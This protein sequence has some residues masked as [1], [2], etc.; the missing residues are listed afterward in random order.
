MSANKAYGLFEIKAVN[1]EKRQITGIATT[2]TADRVGDI[3]EPKG[4][5]F[6]LPLPL[7]W[8][9]DNLQPIGSV[10]SARVTE[11]GIEIVAQL[12]QIATPSNLAARLEEAWQSI[13]SG[14]VRG[15][16]IGFIVKE[17]ADIAGTGGM[18][19]TAWDWLETSA[20]TIPA[21]AE[22]NIQ[23]VKSFDAENQATLRQRKIDA[24]NEK[25]TPGVA[26]KSVKL[27]AKEATTMNISKQIESFL[28][29][30]LTLETAM[31]DLMT[32]AAD[33]GRT[34]ETDESEKF[35]DAETEIKAVN[36]H[37]ERLKSMEVLAAKT[38]VAVPAAAGNSTTTATAA[39]VPAQVS[40]SETPEP[41]IRF[42]RM[43]KCVG[44]A[45]GSLSE[46]ATIAEMRY[47]NDDVMLR[48]MKSGVAGGTTLQST[49]ALPLVP[50]DAGVYADFAEFLRPQTIVGK[51]GIGNIP[52]LRRVPFRTRLISQTSGGNGYWV[53]EGAPKPVTKF[54]FAGT[55]LL[56][57]KVANIAV[58]TD[59]LLRDSSPA[60]DIL[61]R[62]SLA[63]ALRQ[64]IDTT[65]IDP[66]IAA[67]ANISPASI[68][69]GVS[70]IASSGNTIDDVNDDIRAIMST[71]IAANNPPQQGVWIMSAT[72]ALSL[73]LMQNAL[74]QKAFP[75][76]S[77][78]GGTFA[79]LPVI[80][81]EYVTIVTAG[82][83]VALVNASDIYFGDDGDIAVDM[84][85]EAS[86]QMDNAPTND[87]H[88]PTA[89]SLV[90]LWQTNSI[91]FRAER[92]LNWSK[93]RTSAVALLTGVNWGVGV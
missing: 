17:Y 49:W 39:R 47:P 79:G 28:A 75:D 18:R 38:A 82:A 35:K 41:G 26:G 84:S 36:E 11:L 8:Q 74:G 58:I 7:L 59:E 32:K 40:K 46:A 1:D 55:H 29:K 9:H 70:G 15:L 72:T 25:I 31:Q 71:F 63:D 64:I 57:L 76:I 65:F 68:T 42:A 14:L 52:A 45:K 51:F 78:S 20:V 67:S 81:S 73:S 10:I 48:L 19:I 85:R 23:T 30:K 4:A 2:I 3:V 88:T 92:T 89:T 6:K 90:S 83:D 43:V 5:Q 16:S 87:T 80:V 34:L 44:L 69:H 13:K 53:G 37:L 54:D 93:R 91:G 22:A 24:D 50:T 21:N 66:T 77:M 33:E 12:A 61:V 60:A 56:P 86:L 62:N 27:N